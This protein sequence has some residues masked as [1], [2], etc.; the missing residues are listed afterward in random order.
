M[1]VTFS[2][3]RQLSTGGRTMFSGAL[4]YAVIP[5]LILL[6]SAI[7]LMTVGNYGAAGAG[8]GLLVLLSAI[9]S[10]E[11]MRNRA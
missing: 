9:K 7:M 3:F 2:Q 5:V 6:G 1:A 10:W 8:I 4:G 11:I